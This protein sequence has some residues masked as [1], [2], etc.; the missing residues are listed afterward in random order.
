MNNVGIFFGSDTGNT[1][2][3]AKLI[4]NNIYPI[5]SQ[6]F[7]ISNTSGKQITSF[8]FLIFG[9]PTW[10]YGE[11]QSDW[12]DFLPIFKKIN[13]ENKIVALFGCGDQEDYSD[14]FCD[15]MN[16]IYQ[17]IKNNKGYII[18]KWPKTGYFFQ[19]SK[20]LLDKNYFVGLVIDEDRQQDKTTT[21]IKQWIKQIFLEL[22][23]LK[24]K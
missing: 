6:V 23:T 12:D 18:G 17:I 4:S 2:K 19:Q 13:F 3:V 1:E 8:N 16:E 7:D 5:Q 22:E 10:Y 15:A 14:Y 20:A 9:V 21:R 11:L 24:N